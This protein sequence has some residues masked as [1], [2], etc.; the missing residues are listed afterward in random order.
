MLMQG[1]LVSTYVEAADAVIDVLC[2][3]V[4]GSLIVVQRQ[5]NSWFVR[6]NVNPTDSKTTDMRTMK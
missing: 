1:L 3:F 5:L 6:M 2:C 4:H